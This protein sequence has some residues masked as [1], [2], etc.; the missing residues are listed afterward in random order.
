MKNVLR[1]VLITGASDGLGREIA[2]V[3]GSKGWN[4]V[5][6]ARSREK[7]E[8]LCRDLARDHGVEALPLVADLS[9]EGA[10]EQLYHDC[11][12]LW[13]RQ[14][15]A[16]TVSFLV[17]NAGS[18][19]FGEGVELGS[20]A[21][22]MLRLNIIA[23]TSL[24]ALFGR[25]MKDRREGW[26]LNIG[27]LTANQP[28]PFFASYGASKSYIRNYSLALRQELA[29]F[30]VKVSCAQPGFI[31]TNFDENS[32]VKSERYRR[33]SHKN[34]MPAH[35]VAKIAVRAALSGRGLVNIGIANTFT[36]WF[37]KLLPL[38]LL[39]AILARAVFALTGRETA[40]QKL[41]EDKPLIKD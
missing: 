33:F 7:L 40:R 25:D 4:L 20:R 30:G 36:A 15:G 27:S 16:V 2:R 31:R 3:L 10:A 29:P 11:R 39:S 5:L 38:G 28:T 19:L 13:D 37:S 1:W 21:F 23:P 41:G 12:G 26:I 32:G 9:R 8:S 24:C 17:N 35:R 22:P 14:G 18:G 6:T 34:G